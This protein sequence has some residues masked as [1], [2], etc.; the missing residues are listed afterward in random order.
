[1]LN[2][3]MSLSVFGFVFLFLS[4]FCSHKNLKFW[5]DEMRFLRLNDTDAYNIQ[6]QNNVDI[7]KF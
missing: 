6:V 7:Y 5:E 4:F 3:K 2:L 1:M